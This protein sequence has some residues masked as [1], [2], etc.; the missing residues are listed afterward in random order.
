MTDRVAIMV[1]TINERV[2]RVFDSSIEC[3][4]EGDIGLHTPAMV[5]GRRVVVSKGTP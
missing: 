3:P 2:F 1:R 4:E 5:N